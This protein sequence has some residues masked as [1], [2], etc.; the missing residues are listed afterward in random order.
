[1]NITN[2]F[3]KVLDYFRAPQS[4]A[5]MA[6][7]RLQIIIA[8]ERGER[9]KPDYFI[10]MQKELINVIAKYVSID[11]DD[12]KMDLQRKDGYSVLELNITL[13]T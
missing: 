5:K 9:D 12:I 2:Q 3:T 4:T 11:K 8:H 1:M 13:P 6:K 7:E 10:S